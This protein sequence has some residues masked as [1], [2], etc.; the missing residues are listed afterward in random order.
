MNAAYNFMLH[1]NAFPLFIIF[2]FRWARCQDMTFIKMLL[3][4]L[5]LVG[6]KFMNENARSVAHSVVI[7]ETP[8]AQISD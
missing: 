6:I 1:K 3:P 8:I 2:L 7:S 4:L 5:T